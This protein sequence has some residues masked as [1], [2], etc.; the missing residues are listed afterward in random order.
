[1]CTPLSESSETVPATAD[2]GYQRGA[3]G[4]WWAAGL[5]RMA[6]PTPFAQ[7]GRGTGLWAGTL[8]VGHSISTLFASGSGGL[9]PAR[10]RRRLPWQR[11]SSWRCAATT[12]RSRSPT[13]DRRFRPEPMVRTRQTRV[14]YLDT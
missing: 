12:S 8:F 7:R 5:Q 2:P 9:Q 4:H 10:H 14:R 3:A 1:M 13:A 11:S 6:V